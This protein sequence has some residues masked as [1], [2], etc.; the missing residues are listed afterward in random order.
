MLSKVV[1]SILGSN[2]RIFDRIPSSYQNLNSYKYYVI[3]LSEPRSHHQAS[4]LIFR[5]KTSKRPAPGQRQDA[6]ILPS[7][8]PSRGPGLLK[9]R[10]ERVCQLHQVQCRR[11]DLLRHLHQEHRDCHHRSA[12]LGYQLLAEA[13]SHLSGVYLR[14]QRCRW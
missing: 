13:E 7:C 4:P 3:S 14:L 1:T 10:Y 11:V 8:S 9:H 2:E 6:P 12:R 5:A